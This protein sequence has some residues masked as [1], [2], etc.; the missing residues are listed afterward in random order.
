MAS[1]K[2]RI[3]NAVIINR[4][5]LRGRLT[6]ET[7]DFNTSI[8]GF[9]DQCEKGA[10]RFG[11]PPK[12]VTLKPETIKGIVCEWLIPEGSPSDKLILYFHGG[13][14]VSGSC[15]DHRGLVAKF[16]LS[17][18]VTTLLFEYRLAPEDPFPAA[19]DDA[20]TVYTSLLS[21]GYKP[22]NILF[23]GESA[24]GGLCLATLLALKE[25][26]LEL[27]LAAVAISPWTDLAC[28]GESY[29]TKNRVSAAPLNSWTVFS[30]YYVGE[31]RVTNPLISPLYG[32][33]HGLPPLFINAGTSDELFDDGLKF[34]EKAKKSGVDVTF[35]AGE[36]QLHC[37]PF[38]APMFSEATEAMEEIIAFVRKQF[39]GQV[40]NP[41]GK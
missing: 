27:P 3:I 2:S 37:Y 15:N 12:G 10:S 28:T 36:D 1:I 38:F 26:S 19:V 7:F 23:A 14:Y 16:A 40:N 31:D 33:L 21:A 25:K 4:H 6:K 17:A 41:A 5:L 24:G 30:R 11:K 20:V 9:R 22:A 34:Y 18:G 35:R 8:Q 13:G 32:D 29:R 39:A